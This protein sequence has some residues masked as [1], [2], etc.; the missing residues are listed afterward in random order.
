MPTDRLYRCLDCLEHTITRPF[1]TSHL[2]VTCPNCESFER[3]INDA[4]F[5]KFQSLEES[6]PESLRWEELDRQKQLMIS[7]RVVRTG[8]SVEDFSVDG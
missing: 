3:F 4:V 6:P 1:D 5:E 2:S 7:E 8:R